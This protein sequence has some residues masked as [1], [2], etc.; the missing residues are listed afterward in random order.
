VENNPTAETRKGGT[1]ALSE[2]VQEK[3]KEI[4]AWLQRD[5]RDQIRDLDYFEEILGPIS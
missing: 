4:F 2:E 5:A 3:L 1:Q